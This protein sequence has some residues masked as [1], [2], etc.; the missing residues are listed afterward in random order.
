MS[1][2]SY[3]ALQKLLNRDHASLESPGSKK[4]QGLPTHTVKDP[5]I[6]RLGEQQP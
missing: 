2:I 3:I 4:V 1:F 6:Q 5:R